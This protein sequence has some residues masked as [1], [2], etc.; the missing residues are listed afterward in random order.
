M[1]TLWDEDNNL[2]AYNIRP[3]LAEVFKDKP[4]LVVKEVL[5]IDCFCCGGKG[6]IELRENN[7]EE[8]EKC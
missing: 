4:G 1:I 8:V 2:L 7:K 6:Y 5:V 3:E